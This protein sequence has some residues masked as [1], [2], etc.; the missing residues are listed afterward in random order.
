[1]LTM[2]FYIE[3]KR[4]RKVLRMKKN[5]K[6]MVKTSSLMKE[7]TENLMMCLS[8]TNIEG[9]PKENVFGMFFK[10]YKWYIQKKYLISKK[11]FT[12]C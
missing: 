11:C 9:N 4:Y 6:C 3:Q 10:I 12:S 8:T 7:R 2:S 5:I 1:M